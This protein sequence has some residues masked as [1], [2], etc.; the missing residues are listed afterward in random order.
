MVICAHG[1]SREAVFWFLLLAEPPESQRI[2]R[3]SER[4]KVSACTATGRAV[5]ILTSTLS[6]ERE[7]MEKYRA[8][9]V[10]LIILQFAVQLLK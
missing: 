7:H 6:H 3:E 2:V 8:N 4:R 9:D 1:L 10:I 5:G